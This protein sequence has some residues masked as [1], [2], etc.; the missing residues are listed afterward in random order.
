MASLKFATVAGFVAETLS[1]RYLHKK[2]SNGVRS[3]ERGGYST[4][5][6]QES[7]GKVVWF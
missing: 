3:G 1:F 2:K 7:G 6:L 5:P 4:K